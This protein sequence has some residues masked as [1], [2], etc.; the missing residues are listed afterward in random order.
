M[1]QYAGGPVGADLSC[2][3]CHMSRRCKMLRANPK[4]VLHLPG[5]L[6]GHCESARQPP[7]NHVLIR[8]RVIGIDTR[9]K[10]A[11]DVP[12]SLQQPFPS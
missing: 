7:A 5:K 9:S 6:S 1:S 11:K 3:I 12:L 4:D 10:S 2:N 8:Q